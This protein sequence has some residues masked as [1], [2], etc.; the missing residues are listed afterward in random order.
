MN[1]ESSALCVEYLLFSEK[2]V[3]LNIILVNFSVSFYLLPCNDGQWNFST[4][5]SVIPIAQGRPQVRW[6]DDTRELLGKQWK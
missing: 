6:A 1:Q 5:T 3:K 4:D 2:K